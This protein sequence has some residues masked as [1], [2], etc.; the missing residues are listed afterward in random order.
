MPWPRQAKGQRRGRE[1]ELWMWRLILFVEVVDLASNQQFERSNEF[2]L[3][4]KWCLPEGREG[5]IQF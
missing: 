2:D 3:R 5:G 1:G 4:R